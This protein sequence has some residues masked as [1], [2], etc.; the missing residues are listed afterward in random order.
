MTTQPASPDTVLV[1][2]AAG[3]LGRAVVHR[4]R[5]RGTQV[6][7]TD[8]A[9]GLED[10]IGCDVTDAAV[11]E[12]LIARE[13]VTGVIH[14]GAIS[15]PM[16]ARGAPRTIVDVNVDGTANL[17]EAARL[18]GLR[19]V[20]ICSSLTVYGPTD[21][22]AVTETM[23]TNPTSVYAASKVAGEA[24]MLA[25]AAQHGVD[26]VALRIGTVYGPG[27]RTAC[28]VR[29]V[30]E[31]A[32]DG[33][34]TELPFGRD[35]PRQYLYVD[36]AADALVLAWDAE[37]VPSRVYNIGGGSYLT[38]RGVADAAADVVPGVDV[39]LGEGPDPDDPDRQGPLSTE[40]AASELGYRPKW[41][42][43]EGLEAYAAWLQ[44]EE[45]RRG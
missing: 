37:T 3:L 20:V 44:G 9:P 16:V 43:A 28:F 10:V 34:R 35:F 18:H 2:G 4:L 17:L 21:A 41:T 7:A 19:R 12:T 11:V 8:V 32:R 22:A 1:T 23:A 39:Q 14:C 6:V 25:Y 26:G 29:T 45:E 40:R 42:L 30:L 38:M 15:G 24:L 31:D 5:G 27:R 33:R 36:D 13:G